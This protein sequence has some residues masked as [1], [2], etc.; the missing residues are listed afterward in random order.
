MP[1]I[2]SANS[3]TY[4]VNATSD[5]G[6]T[7]TDSTTVTVLEAVVA[8]A[9]A[10]ATICEGKSV[11]LQAT[12]GGSYLWSPGSALDNNKV[13][14]PIASPVD[15]TLYV[16]TVSNGICKAYDSVFVNVLKKPVANAGPDQRIFEGQSTVLNGIALG[17][18]ISYYWSPNTSISSLTNMQPTVSPNA[19]TTYTLH[20]T[21]NVGCGTAADDVFVRVYKKVVVPNAFSP[22]GDGINDKWEIKSLITYP[23]SETSVFNRYGQPVF[24]AKGY[25]NPWN[26]KYNNSALPVGTYYYIIDL[27]NDLPKLSGWVMILR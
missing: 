19:D 26:G 12:G 2:T 23:D 16:L 11:A 21:S 18:N 10:D 24:V 9:G 14:N 13:S 22:N 8:N 3:G 17:T 6:C 27:K 15:T 20:I 25:S 5:K 7:N 1:N 4:Y